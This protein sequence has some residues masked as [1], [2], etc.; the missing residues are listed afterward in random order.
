MKVCIICMY[1]VF[2]KSENG[3]L[4]P[5]IVVINIFI[6]FINFSLKYLFLYIAWN[7]IYILH[8]KYIFLDTKYNLSYNEIV[9]IEKPYFLS[10]KKYFLKIYFRFNN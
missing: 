2:Q 4:S 7:N 10:I 6:K 5:K 3:Q 1:R 8:F 9:S